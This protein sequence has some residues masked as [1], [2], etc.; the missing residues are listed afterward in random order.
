MALLLFA[1]KEDGST[2][3]ARF[4]GVLAEKEGALVLDR[5][6]K[7]DFPLREEWLSRIKEPPAH[8]SD[9]VGGAELVLSLSVGILEGSP[10][11]LIDTGLQWPEDPA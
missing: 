7:G 4:M 2:E 6:E 11:D 3:G 9:V 10:E 8:L 1:D 5:G